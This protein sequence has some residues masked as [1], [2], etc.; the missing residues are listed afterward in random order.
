MADKC[1]LYLFPSELQE[2]ISAL[3]IA[4]NA[5]DICRQDLPVQPTPGETTY[6]DY[7]LKLAV[8]QHLITKL[9]D[10][11]QARRTVARP[12]MADEVIQ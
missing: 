7:T 11:N 12:A 8:L 5:I 1:V 9:K 4:S 3:R 10:V 2:L 6:A